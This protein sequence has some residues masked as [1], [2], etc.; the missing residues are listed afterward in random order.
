MRQAALALAL[1]A[2]L[3]A[4]CGDGATTY[5]VTVQFNTSVT[6]ADLDETAALLR[7]YDRDLD[8]LI[9][10]S[11]PPTGRA[12]LET[13]VRNFCPTVEGQLAGRTYLQ[14][15]SCERR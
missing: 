5:D 1:L 11:F 14:D 4:A 12:R 2:A 10:E 8:F 6:Q 9:Q 15:V 3:A 13:D 7:R